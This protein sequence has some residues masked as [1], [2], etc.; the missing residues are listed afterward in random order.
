MPRSFNL[1]LPKDPVAVARA[2][3]VTLLLATAVAAY[4]VLYPPGGSP[5]QLRQQ[6]QALREEVLQRTRLLKQTR[7]NVEKIERGRGEGDQF[8]NAYFLK[9]RDA[10]ST[11]VDEL[12]RAAREAKISPKEHS[13]QLEEIEG[14]DNM[15]MMSINGNY[16]GS[17][18]DLMEFI[19]RLD[20]SERMLILE[21]LSA[22]PQQGKGILT[23]NI[24]MDTFVRED[25]RGL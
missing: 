19:N 25:A 4:L 22:A 21:S 17:Y 3:F 23:V 2:V 11:L 16:E 7:A 10:S 8:I 5:Q 1:Q 9:A 6:V 20:R 24:K 15:K 12:T 14:S 18:A 13:I